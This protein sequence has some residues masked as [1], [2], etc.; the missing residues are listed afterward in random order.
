MIGYVSFDI[1]VFSTVPRHASVA[2]DK[3]R[4]ELALPYAFTVFAIFHPLTAK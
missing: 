4:S 3:A 2:F 1:A